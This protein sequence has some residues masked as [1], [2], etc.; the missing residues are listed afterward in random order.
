MSNLLLCLEFLQRE[1]SNLQ[2]LLILLH[3]CKGWSCSSFL[4][5]LSLYPSSSKIAAVFE[6]NGQQESALGAF[7]F[8]PSNPVSG[9]MIS[10][11]PV[12]GL[13]LGN[14][15]QQLHYIKNRKLECTRLLSDQSMYNP[16]S[17][18]LSLR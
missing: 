15:Q 14:M 4:N 8:N 13:N 6:L 5:F 9:P 17:D 3:R 10:T 18:W 7:R 11:S 16:A 2:H 12:G 1:I